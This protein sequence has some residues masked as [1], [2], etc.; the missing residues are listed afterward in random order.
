MNVKSIL[1]FQISKRERFLM[2]GIIVTII[3]LF[4][5]MWYKK[6]NIKITKLKQNIS[7]I[8]R[9]GK[10][11]S[12]IVKQ[13]KAKMKQKLIE[14]KARTITLEE[15]LNPTSN[16]AKILNKVSHDSSKRLIELG[17]I[18]LMNSKI[19][20]QIRVN[21]FRIQIKSL[22]IDLSKFLENLE[23]TADWISITAVEISR[24]EKELSE[25]QGIV[26]FDT[27]EIIKD[28]K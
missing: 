1:H 19:S 21:T 18:A 25:C 24:F 3:F 23:N 6:Q 15:E 26:F 10:S 22:F 9:T 4:Y 28:Q 27:Y 8:E 20:E 17:S 2:V 13:L 16:I 14:T 12:S 5:S 7:K 11:N